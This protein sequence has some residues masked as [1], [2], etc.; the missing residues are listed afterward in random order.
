MDVVKRSRCY[1]GIQHATVAQIGKCLAHRIGERAGNGVLHILLIRCR[2]VPISK[3]GQRIASALQGRIRRVICARICTGQ[4]SRLVRKIRDGVISFLCGIT[5][6]TRRI[7]KYA[8]R[9]VRACTIVAKNV[10]Q[11]AV[12]LVR[13]CIVCA[14]YIAEGAICPLHGLTKVIGIIAD[15]LIDGSQ[16]LL[17]P[18]HR[19]TKSAVRTLQGRIVIV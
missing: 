14:C 19:I 5:I 12:Y 4:I 7:A 15:G 8:V 6:C 1:G 17:V 3:A 11:T 2:E 9:L 16:C 13:R 10:I 18:V